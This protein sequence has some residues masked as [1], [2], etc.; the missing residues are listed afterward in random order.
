MHHHNQALTHNIDPFSLPRQAHE[1]GDMDAAAA[2]AAAA[3][4]I[5]TPFPLSPILSL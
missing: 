3:S 4:P 5:T 2:A 1:P